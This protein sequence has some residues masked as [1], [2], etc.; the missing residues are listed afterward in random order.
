MVDL[1]E[2]QQVIALAHSYFEAHAYRHA[3][4]VLSEALVHSPNDPALLRE[5]ARAEVCLE[6]WVPGAVHAHA[7]LTQDPHDTQAMR[8]YAL[9]LDGLNRRAEAIWMA[10]RTVVAAPNEYLSH[11][12]YGRLLYRAGHR[13]QALAVVD[14]AL[15]LQPNDPDTWALRGAILRA[16]NRIVDSDSAYEQALRIQPDHATSINDMA[17]NRLRQ[18]RLSTALRGFLGAA[19]IDPT[20]G[21]LTRTNVAVTL[22]TAL[23]RIS[24][25]ATAVGLFVAA[26]GI[27]A[28]GHQSPITARVFAAVAGL[29]FLAFFVMALRLVPARLWRVALKMKPFLALRVAHAAFTVVGAAIATALAGPN[30]LVAFVG[31][32]IVL[33]G[34][35]M[36]FVGR[37]DYT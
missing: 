21:T 3:Y 10:W 24:W 20:I 37:F 23:R 5:L 34:L 16:L 12:T 27:P 26:V 30:G 32:A 35:F 9:A 17:L 7:A 1:S 22:T 36:A 11:Y 14:E 6:Q 19:N 31:V 28:D 4:E 33:G 25:A 2:P 13:H 18:G 15:R 8:I 29:V